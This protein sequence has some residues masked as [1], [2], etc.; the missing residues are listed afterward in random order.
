MLSKLY[1]EIK[2]QMKQNYKFMVLFFILLFLFTVPLPYYVDTP[3]GIMNVDSKM[4]IENSFPSKGSFNLSYV[5]ELKGTLPILFISQ[6]QKDW[7]VIKKE[8]IVLENETVKESDN[9]NR[10]MLEE[11]NQNAIYVAYKKA[12][13]EVIVTDFS[14]VVTYLD[15]NSKT[16]LEVGDEILEV[17]GI[18][19]TSKEEFSLVL[20]KKQ[21]GEK[22]QMKVLRNK[23]ENTSFA[24]LYEIDNRKI[25]GAILAEKKE[26]EM[27]P[28]ITFTFD[29]S[30]SGPSGGLMMSLAI[31]NA[32][33][34]EDITHGKTIVGTGTMESDGTV[35]EIG[36]IEYKLKG[37]VKAHADLFFVPSGDNY[38]EAS[39]LKEENHY[40]I[41]IVPVNSFDDALSYLE[42]LK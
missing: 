15:K 9:R 10:M 26:L 14:L 34:E 6:F 39:A 36:G 31:Y 25:I 19:M 24:E 38:L 1:E 29:S 16:N 17:D 42:T 11:T 33:I 23:E 20:S 21:V 37:A 32:L 3:G 13:K 8:E 30:E 35:G 18:S 7:N 5:S 4:E 27:N 40:M 2:K 28:K 22:V 12:A 41:P